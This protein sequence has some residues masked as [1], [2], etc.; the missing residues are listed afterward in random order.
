MTVIWRDR[1][2]Q[3]L[4]EWAGGYRDRRLAQMRD[5]LER[6][7]FRDKYDGVLEML[8]SADS[9]EEAVE[10]SAMAAKR[11]GMPATELWISAMQTGRVRAHG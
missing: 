3:P 6:F 11:L 5:I 9:A 4:T 1:L 2:G 10:L 8:Q 7:D